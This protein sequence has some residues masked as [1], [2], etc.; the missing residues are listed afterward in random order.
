MGKYMTEADWKNSKYFKKEE[1]KCKCKGKYCNGYPSEIAKSLVDTMNTIR[2][3]YG[4]S[5]T[6]TSGLRCKTNNKLVGGA[7]NSK[8]LT[9]LA[10][11]FNFTGQLLMKEQKT[12]IIKYIKTLPNIHYTYTNQSN[13][14]NA[15]HVDTILVDDLKGYSGTFPKLPKNGSLNYGDSGTQ[16]KNLQNFLNWCIDS[17]LVVDGEFGPKTEEAVKTYQKTYSLTVDGYFGPK[18]LAKAKTIKK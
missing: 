18:S 2:S 16:V 12:S 13:M 7:T 6:I 1:F 3:K 17:K 10:C 9:G 5:I 11:D 8:H 14:Y 15:I 4:K